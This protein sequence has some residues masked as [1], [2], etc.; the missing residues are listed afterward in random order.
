MNN[1]EMFKNALKSVAE[2]QD[3]RYKFD[4]NWSREEE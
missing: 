2:I 4:W 3:Y 1:P